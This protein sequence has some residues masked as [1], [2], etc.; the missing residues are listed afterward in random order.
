MNS[1]QNL[2]TCANC[3]HKTSDEINKLVCLVTGKTVDSGDSCENYTSRKRDSQEIEHFGYEAEKEYFSTKLYNL[4]A[5]YVI[6]IILGGIFLY[7]GYASDPREHVVM[8]V[9]SV[10]VI[11]VAAVV[12]MVL[13]YNIWD[14]I[15]REL[16]KHGLK[17]SVETPG[18]AVGFL[19]IPF[20]NF[21]WVFI[22]LGKLP[23]DLNRIAIARTGKN[24]M[25]SEFG[26]IICITTL[27]SVVPVLGTVLAFLNLVL[28]PAFF[29]MA[30][31]GIKTIPYSAGVEYIEKK[32]KEEPLDIN[33]VSDYSQ[34]FDK[35]KYGVNLW[36]GLFY[37]VAMVCTQIVLNV[38]YF[39]S[40]EIALLQYFSISNMLNLFIYP[41]LFSAVL[42]V[43]SHAVRNKVVLSFSWGLANVI[44]GVIP[45]L[46]LMLN[47]ND[48]YQQYIFSRNFLIQ[49]STNFLNSVLFILSITFFLR[50]YGLKLW[51]ILIAISI[52]SLLINSY[53][54]T[55]TYLVDG[56]FDFK[57]FSFVG[58]GVHIVFFTAAIYLAFLQYIKGTK[59]VGS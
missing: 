44:L 8:I 56:K 12:S 25:A 58:I 7:I 46:L 40:N 14:F 5:A 20:F 52:P 23:V 26:I 36:F 30:I 33:T 22:A 43:L 11:L 45:F 27:L 42:V 31:N 35:A 48:Y 34:L 50:V 32:H 16:G 18:K 3:L 49:V 47:G 21:Y 54:Y 28:M 59:T 53:F 37:F 51:S 19:F 39:I 13:L 1:H 24:V 57:I 15:I 55:T 2:T 4:F 17:P 10:L 38:T 9:V 29:I 6:G 41:L